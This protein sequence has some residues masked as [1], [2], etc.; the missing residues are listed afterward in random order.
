VDRLPAGVILRLPAAA[1]DRL[2]S[3]EPVVLRFDLEVAS[4]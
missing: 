2:E 4:S 3:G 1:C